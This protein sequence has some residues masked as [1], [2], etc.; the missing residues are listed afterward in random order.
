[1]APQGKT[2]IYVAKANAAATKAEKA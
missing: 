2:E 1:M